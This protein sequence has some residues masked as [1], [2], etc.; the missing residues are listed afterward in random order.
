MTIG[1]NGTIAPPLDLLVRADS[2]PGL[3]RNASRLRARATGASP[4]ATCFGRATADSR[5]H[6][7]IHPDTASRAARCPDCL[8]SRSD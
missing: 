3:R 7:G 2:A 6:R 1:S 4:R 5:P 8:A